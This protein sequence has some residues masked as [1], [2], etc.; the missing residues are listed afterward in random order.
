MGKKYILCRLII[1]YA[2]FAGF[3]VMVRGNIAGCSES[4]AH[5]ILTLKHGFI[6]QFVT[7]SSVPHTFSFFL[8]FYAFKNSAF[9]F[10]TKF[11]K[12]FRM[13]I[14]SDELNAIYVSTVYYIILFTI[15]SSFRKKPKKSK[16][17]M[18]NSISLSMIKNKRAFIFKTALLQPFAFF[19]KLKYTTDIYKSVHVDFQ[20]LP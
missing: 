8:V 5:K 7:P 2:T 15:N 12:L 1:T 16:N 10:S 14:I 6:I 4:D 20:N 18:F 17:T 9:I 19:S 3:L 13:V 11:H